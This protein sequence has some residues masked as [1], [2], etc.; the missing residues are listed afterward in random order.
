MTRLRLVE[1]YRSL[2]RYYRF[3]RGA[4]PAVYAMHMAWRAEHKPLPF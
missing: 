3:F 1:K 2:R 4:H